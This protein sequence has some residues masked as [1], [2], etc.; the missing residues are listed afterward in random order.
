MLILQME[1]TQCLAS[2]SHY[3][4]LL[5]K[6]ASIVRGFKIGVTKNARL[7]HSGFEWQPRFHDHIIRDD[8]SFQNISIYI[9]NNPIN[10]Q[11][12]NFFKPE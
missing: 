12:N 5:K 9:I 6:F 11:K 4:Q 8:K 1:E 3:R 10:W 7:I 2:L